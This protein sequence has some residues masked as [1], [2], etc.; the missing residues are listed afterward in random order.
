[1]KS[2]FLNLLRDPATKAKLEYR[3]AGSEELLIS[4][5]GKKYRIENGIARFI[6]AEELE[7]NNRRYVKLYDRIA[8]VYD[9]TTT[10]Y[11]SFKEGSVRDRLMQYLGK[12]DVLDGQTVIE[13]SIGTGRNIV[14]MNPRGDYYGVDISIGMLR[15][16]QKVIRKAGRGIGLI[17][18]EAESL[19][20][21]DESFDVV[22]SAGGFN[23]FNDRSR[24][25]NEMLRIAKSGT[26]LLI[27]DETEKV[28][29]RLDKSPVTR[30]FY[31]QEKI[32]DPAA[33]VPEWC[34]EV[35]YEEVCGG[36]LYALTFRKP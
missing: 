24:A 10:L 33:F 35:R 20:L 14:Y 12:I 5:G 15:R 8:P 19:P 27:S 18:A 23:F 29:A 31:D 11:A 7:A 2:E 28:R 4:P 34:K 9:L 26:K 25:M 16:C 13:I 22:F 30:R 1:M 6:K 3:T 17:Q 36:E 21:A 32:T